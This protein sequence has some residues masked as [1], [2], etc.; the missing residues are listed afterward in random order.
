[1]TH[2]IVIQEILFDRKAFNDFSG[3]LEKLHVHAVIQREHVLLFF[4]LSLA[5]DL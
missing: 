1:M 2:A 3:T 4:N 5:A